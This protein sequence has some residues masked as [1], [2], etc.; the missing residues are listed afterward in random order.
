V[1]STRNEGFDVV[2]QAIDSHRAWLDASGERDRRRA[3][4]ATAEIA[5]IVMGLAR[6]HLEG[7]DSGRALAR[8]ADQVASGTIDPFTAAD[9]LLAALTSGT[10]D[11]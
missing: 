3:H 7:L 1:I 10:R 8:A 5:G 4:R 2:L 11:A 9:E 6:Q